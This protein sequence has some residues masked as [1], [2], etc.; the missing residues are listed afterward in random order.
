Q[1]GDSRAY[2][3]R[4]EEIHQL[5]KDQSLVQLLIDSGRIKPEEADRYPNNVITQAIGADSKLRP[6]LNQFKLRNNDYLL[7][8]SDGLTNKVRDEEM[9]QIVKAS[10][11]LDVA[12][13]RLVNLANTRGG[14]DNIT[15]I[16]ARFDGESLNS[17]SSWNTGSLKRAS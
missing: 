3:I 5:T 9:L 14:E 11:S 16:I 10:I 17:S 8:C 7:I 2:L 13:R 1:V 15:V 12:C 4:E 6:A